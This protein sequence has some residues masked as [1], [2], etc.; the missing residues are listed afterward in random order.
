MHP[1]PPSAFVA[2]SGTALFAHSPPTTFWFRKWR[3]FYYLRVLL[4]SQGHYST[5][6][7][8]QS[9]TTL[10]VE[11][12]LMQHTVN[13]IITIS[14][15]WTRIQRNPNATCNS[16]FNSRSAYTSTSHWDVAHGWSGA[17]F[18]FT[19]LYAFQ[20]RSVGCN[21]VTSVCMN[22]PC[23]AHLG[24]NEMILF[25]LGRKLTFSESVYLYKVPTRR[26]NKHLN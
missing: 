23:I 8:S 12:R 9:V 25:R 24:Q 2:C 15:F 1:L 22:A 3:E 11:Y 21:V 5:E 7:V 20:Q 19:A 10:L 6:L 14:C 16:C 17:I 4:A 26:P 18:I 13:F